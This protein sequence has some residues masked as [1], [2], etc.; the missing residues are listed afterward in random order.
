VRSNEETDRSEEE[1]SP[2]NL[3]AELGAFAGRKE[4]DLVHVLVVSHLAVYLVSEE[5]LHEVVELVLVEMVAHVAHRIVWPVCVLNPVQ[6]AVVLG[7]P[8]A[9]LE[10]LQVDG[11]VEGVAGGV[12]GGDGVAVVAAELLLGQVLVELRVR[13]LLEALSL[14]VLARNQLGL[15]VLCL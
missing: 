9:V 6:E 7:H 13:E 5:G 12:Q 2:C 4:L 1:R 10:L 14:L 3:C 11:G 8:E 15:E